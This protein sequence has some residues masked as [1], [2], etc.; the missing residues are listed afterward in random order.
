MDGREQVWPWAAVTALSSR[1]VVEKALALL[2]IK[3]FILS[4]LMFLITVMQSDINQ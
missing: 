3:Y 1:E 2:F 4:T